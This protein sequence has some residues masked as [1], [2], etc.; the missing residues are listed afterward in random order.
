MGKRSLLKTEDGQ[1]D[2]STV[3]RHYASLVT[4]NKQ[5]SFARTK[6][7]TGQYITRVNNLNNNAINTNLQKIMQRENQYNT[8]PLDS[9]KAKEFKL[10]KS[11]KMY[12]DKRQKEKVQ[13]EN[14]MIL[15]RLSKISAGRGRNSDRRWSSPKKSI[16]EAI[17]P[18]SSFALRQ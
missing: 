17:A 10:N 6:T 9:V 8:R 1:G 15:D 3:N 2:S 18:P 4:E 5:P 13:R 7:V 16:T 12:L 11:R 14:N